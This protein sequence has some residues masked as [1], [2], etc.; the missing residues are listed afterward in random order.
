MLIVFVLGGAAAATAAQPNTV[1]FKR[2]TLEDGLSQS[3]V[4]AMAQDRW[5]FMWFGT[6]D[7]LNRYDGYRFTVFQHDAQ[8]AHS[9]SANW[10]ATLHTDQ[11]D[12]LWVGTHGGGLNRYDPETGHFTAYRH[13]PDDP[14][15]LAHDIISV[16]HEDGEGHLWIGT[17]GG[18][19]HFDPGT[20]LFRTYRH[21]PEDP[22]SLPHNR[23]LALAEDAV[24]TLWVGTDGGGLDRL[25]PAT[26]DFT[27]ARLDPAEALYRRDDVVLALYRDRAGVLWI[28]TVGGALNRFDPVAGAYRSYRHDPADPNSLSPGRVLSIHED[29]Q[30]RLWI[31]T[32]GGG[33]SRLDAATGDFTRIRHVPADLYSLSNDVVSA[34][35][36]DRAGTLWVGTQGGGLNKKT[37]FLPYRHQPGDPFSLPN[38]APM[39]FVQAQDGTLWVGT[40]GGGLSRLDPTTGRFTTY[41]HSRTDP[42]SLSHNRVLD[43]AE[44]RDGTLWITTA[45]GLDR[46]DPEASGEAAATVRFTHFRHDPEDS[47]S[48]SNNRV[49][50]YYQP[51]SNPDRPWV[52]TWNGLNRFDPVT[53]RFQTYRHDPADPRSLSNN[54]VISIH[55]DKAGLLWVGT[56]GGGLNRFD[57]QTGRFTAFKHDPA[58]PRSLSHDIVASI[59]EDAAGTLWVS[60]GQGL[61]RF[62]PETASFTRFTQRDGLPNNTIYGILEDRRG[63]LWMSTNKGLSHLDPAT[64]TFVNYDVGDGLQSNEFSQGSYYKSASGEF[65]FGGINGFNRFHPDSLLGGTPPPV[66]LTS[67][68]TGREAEGS[69]PAGAQTVTLKRENTFSFEFAALDF[70]NPA[71]N[72]YA[73]KLDGFDTDWNYREA[74][75]RFAV[76]SNLAGGAYTLRVKAANADGLWNDAGVALTITVVPPFWQT[77]WFRLLAAA[78]LLGMLGSVAY[79]WH[80]V[81]IRRVERMRDERAE[82]Q[83]RLTESR[84][85]E[86][87][88][89]AQELHDGAVQD[90]YGVRFNLEMLSGV[91]ADGP[92]AE[93]LDQG[94]DMVQE[95]IKKLRII[96]G[97]LRPPALAPFGLERAI[98][99][100]AEQFEETHAGLA[101]ALTLTPDGQRLPETMRLAL[102][103][104]YQ[105]AMNNIIKHA[106]AQQVHVRLDLDADTVTLEIRD[107]GRGFVLPERWIELGRQEHYGLLG[108][109]E[110]VDALEGRLEVR[111]APEQ[112]TTVRV[113]APLPAPMV[114]GEWSIDHG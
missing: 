77:W 109:A 111:S 72:R 4:Y 26:G 55:E 112:G 24:G 64:E 102:Y 43:V 9:I 68:S 84:E 39:A 46:L 76:Y 103:R 27:A 10:V 40:D 62:D 6:Q 108:I 25:D 82:I 35:Y 15:S 69:L 42:N 44:D 33:L 11:D 67:F 91:L 7:G 110:R 19:S 94:K 74:D 50:F 96:C 86:R 85:A 104:V 61:N 65:F 1:P 114:N 47:I 113:T 83:R 37:R 90:L 53:G 51:P 97:D 79:A 78:A 59:H 45:N 60:T 5:G 18:L 56:F 22:K 49:F 95:V 75:R 17:Y 81:R 107:D 23:V 93:P 70:A 101:V 54:R 36:A 21:D 66:M 63:G 92:D 31:G 52:G 30:G 100:H 99:S 73:F 105:E 28:G 41:T 98:R 89:L 3:A 34:I 48:L 14:N 80:R 32:D 106:Q 16:I 12:A 38:N 8:D 29:A 58:D 71:K 13:H 87:L 57:P 88:F 20:G 2:I